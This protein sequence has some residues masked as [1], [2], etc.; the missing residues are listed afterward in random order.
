MPEL[1]IESPPCAVTEEEMA[2]LNN[3]NSKAWRRVTP[4]EREIRMV[5]IRARRAAAKTTTPDLQK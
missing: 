2:G 3:P 5:E 1:E 4:E